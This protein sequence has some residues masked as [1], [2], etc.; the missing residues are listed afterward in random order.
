MEN[1]IHTIQ[2]AP[3]M[4][5]LYL[6]FSPFDS[7]SAVIQLKVDKSFL[8]IQ[9][10]LPFGLIIR[11]FCNMWTSWESFASSC[12][13]LCVCAL[14]LAT[15]LWDFEIQLSISNESIGSHYIK[16]AFKWPSL[17]N[18]SCICAC[19]C[20][21]RM[22]VQCEIG[23]VWYCVIASVY[24]SDRYLQTRMRPTF[25]MQNYSSIFQR[26][27]MRFLMEYLW[28]HICWKCLLGTLHRH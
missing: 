10:Y 1:T 24:Q 18:V 3:T 19:L 16:I 6:I 11:T 21:T 25:E 2:R 27:L 12:K 8:L 7:F 28:R 22:F 5:L 20:V 17:L 9:I 14:M 26:C 23:N 4:K 15:I 13:Y